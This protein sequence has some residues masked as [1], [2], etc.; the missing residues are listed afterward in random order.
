MNCKIGD[1]VRFLNSVGGGIVVRFMNKN[2]VAVQ[3]EDGFEIP[4]SINEIV[5]INEKN[6][7]IFTTES[8]AHRPSSAVNE[9]KKDEEEDED[10]FPDFYVP[11]RRQEE[12]IDPTTNNY[13]VLLGFVPF[14]KQNASTADL[15]IY[16]INDGD[17]R[18][19]YSIGKWTDKELLKPIGS[20]LMEP[21]SKERICTLNR[22][23]FSKIQVFNVSLIYFKN[24]DFIP[25]IPDQLN[26]EL[27][28]LKFVKANS[29]KAN[30]YFDEEAVVFTVSTS[31]KSSEPVL[32]IS[33]KD[34][35]S[36]LKE[37]KD[38]RPVLNLKST[39]EQEEIDLHIEAI[40]ENSAG[41][42]NGEILEMQMARFTTVL[43]GAII[44]KTKRVVFIHGVGN[45]KLKHE[46]RK[47]LERKYPKLRF[48]DASFKDYG[49]GATMV[50]LK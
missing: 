49:Y 12:A 40:T 41:L 46:I 36:A 33:P 48:Q 10:E 22:E 35:E 37:K 44:S 42:S 28:P 18:I 6:D 1:K 3:D 29:F 24:R 45:G 31:A 4:V 43:E 2:I 32:A 5:V 21:D 23:D 9:P 50:I 25:V 7:S 20:G 19:A 17:Y 27:N 13:N 47:T 15:D 38:V 34:I 11:E 39:P 14:N 16:I 30:D 8:Y 26:I